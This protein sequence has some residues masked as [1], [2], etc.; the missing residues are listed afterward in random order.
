M[1]RAL[2]QLYVDLKASGLVEGTNEF[3]TVLRERKVEMCK[4]MRSLASCWDCD[5]FDD[6]EM[7]KSYLRDLYNVEQ[8]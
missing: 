6:C 5:Y 2:K 1:S 7:I 3:D 4:Q 8:K